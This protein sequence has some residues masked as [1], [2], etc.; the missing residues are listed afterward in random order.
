MAYV[1]APMAGVGTIWSSRCLPTHTILQF[2]DSQK[3]R[4][5]KSEAVSQHSRTKMLYT[6]I[7]GRLNSKSRV[8]TEILS[9]G[10]NIQAYAL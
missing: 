7:N 6:F 2:Y 4:W 9:K 8:D 10:V 5:I 1:Q 3:S